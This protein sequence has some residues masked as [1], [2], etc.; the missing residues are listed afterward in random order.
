MRLVIVKAGCA[1]IKRMR[2]LSIN[3]PKCT[4]SA[5]DRTQVRSDF[6]LKQSEGDPKRRPVQSH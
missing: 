3:R 4:I 5:E 6:I 1:D 2:A